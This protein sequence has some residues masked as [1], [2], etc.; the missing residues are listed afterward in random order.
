VAKRLVIVASLLVV[1]LAAFWSGSRYPALNEKLLMGVDTPV[2]GLAFSTLLEVAPDEKPLPKILYTT[3]NWTYTNRQGMTFG[4]LAGALGMGLMGLLSRGPFGNRLGNTVTGMLVGTPMGVCVNC[5]AP[6]GKAVHAGGASVETML[7]LM[8]SSPTLNIVVLTMLLALF[9]FYMAAIKIALTLGFVL[10]GI[11]LL[12][13]WLPAPRAEAR[14]ADESGSRASL[15]QGATGRGALAGGGASARGESWAQAGRW[16]LGSFAGNLW[17]LTKTTVPLMLLAGL[18]GSVLV[19]LVPLE[20]LVER[21][22]RPGGLRS[23]VGLSGVAL[24]GVFLPVPMSFDV[25]VTAMLWR[26][27]L[28]TEYAMVLLFTLGIFSIFPFLLVWRMLGRWPANALFFGL[29]ALGLVAGV[30][31]R[32]AHA[33][34]FE[35]R[36][37]FFLAELS[38]SSSALRGPKRI[39]VGGEAREATADAPLVAGLR[40]AAAT[41]E[42]VPLA[43]SDG[44]RVER[45]PLLGPR[46][47]AGAE[48]APARPFTRLEA[49]RLGLADPVAFSVLSFEVPSAV[50]RGIASGDV[51]NDGWPDL[52]LTS[53]RGPRLYANRPGEGWVAQ[54]IDIPALRDLHVTH[55]A[56]VDLDGDGWLDLYL[57]TYRRG[58]FVVYNREGRFLPEQLQPLP[59]AEG[60]IM[61]GAAAFG[62]LDGDGDL[63]IVVG[64]YAPPVF[65]GAPP[66]QPGILVLLQDGAGGFRVVPLKEI[67]NLT[68]SLL[69]S[70]I[71]GD[72]RLDLIAGNDGVVPDHFFVGLGDGGFREI[73]RE[74]GMVPHSTSTTMSISSADIDNDLRPEIYLGQITGMS[75]HGTLRYRDVGP[76][77]CDEIGEPREAASCREAA[78]VQRMLPDAGRQRDAFACL[79]EDVGAYREDC[80][81]YALLQW[82]RLEGAP[83]LCELFPDRWEAFRFL[84]ES[85]RGEPAARGAYAGGDA[86]PSIVDRNVLLAAGPDGR[87]SDVAHARNVELAGFTWN[88]KFADLDHDEFVDLYAVNGWLSDARQDANVFYRNQRGETFV[89]AT[90]AAGLDSFL[91]TTSYTYIDLD[92]DGDLDIVS[93][94][95][96][97]PLLV[98]LNNTTRSRIAFELRDAIGNRSG[99]GSRLVIRYGPDGARQ[100]MRELQMS[101]GFGSFD[102]PLVYFGLGDFAGV[103]QVEITWSTGERSELRGDFRAGSRY[104]ISRK[105]VA[106][107]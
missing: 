94:P 2:E 14:R 80:I 53:D 10:I 26:A 77:L 28:P 34:D 82:A 43:A 13:R 69:L 8:V 23:L 72:G 58:H 50:F 7:A 46:G 98:H 29:A 71:D 66:V 65:R 38:R 39:P 107:G 32:E 83:G 49:D 42:L 106:G 99:I 1:L 74:D 4:L 35:R 54:R 87:F 31:G 90:E 81:A 70:D 12:A 92:N 75:H 52:V 9:P 101:G 33:W 95:I 25:L 5:A 64:R 102:A 62:D 19:T 88:A 73:K 18:L 15:A 100:Q 11:P 17:F 40:R 59:G 67:P 22:P 24:I 89:D 41:P 97:G 56:L 68:L 6:I 78:Q 27:G 61:N 3:V 76:K 103:E 105:A 48:G 51:H 47:A 96:A 20:S 63:D 37:A 79:S 55:A 16:V 45:V 84:C 91:A 93:A 21:L 85:G 44:V 57:S 86:I 104:I 60:A 36:Q 30:L